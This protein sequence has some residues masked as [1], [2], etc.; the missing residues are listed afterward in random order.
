VSHFAGYLLRPGGQRDRG[1]EQAVLERMARSP[2]LTLSVQGTDRF[3]LVC[4]TVPARRADDLVLHAEGG[5]SVLAGEPLNGS[6]TEPAAPAAEALFRRDALDGSVRSLV[7]SPGTFAVAAW[8]PR[9]E[10]LLLATDHVA[11]R[12]LYFISD[13]QHIAFATSLRLL[14]ALLP[15]GDE[16]DEQGVAE[17]VFFGQCLGSRTPFK[18]VQVLRPGQA[19]RVDAR[20]QP[21]AHD[22]LDRLNRP[23]EPVP[24]GDIVQMLHHAFAKAVSRR[25]RPGPQEAFLSGGMDSR[26]VVAALTD[27]GRPVRSFCTAYAGSLDDIVSRE[28]A[29]RLGTRH[30]IKHRTPAERVRVA[31][32]PFAQYARE[33]FPPESGPAVGRRLWSGDGG[34]V[35]LGHVYM[36]RDSVA[37]AAG[38]L[39]HAALMQLFPALGRRP[40]RQLSR[41]T[42]ARWAELAEAGAA[43]EFQRLS[44]APP[45]RRL[46]HFYMQNDQARHLYHH[47][48]G[49]DLNGIELLT[50]FFDGDFVALVSRLPIEPF[51][52]HGIY[53]RW[54][55]GFR[56]GAGEVYW[57][58][59]RGHEPCPHP[60]PV[61]TAD[62]WDQAW[63]AGAEVRRA[64]RDIARQVLGRGPSAA[65]RFVS[66][67][68][69]RAFSWFNAAGS[70]RFDHEIAFA[71]N[72]SSLFS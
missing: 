34:S 52:A 23:I 61:V 70:T 44:G 7:A 31:L 30:V 50:P 19:L 6:D 1:R 48:D 5:V 27:A 65:D 59:Y 28:V 12:S 56:C 25:L 10:T 57:Q 13:D 46:F 15:S 58:T 32:D 37:V 47:F 11:S 42:T 41:Q 45:E 21:S 26:A 14:R 38:R 24:P 60:A 69:L 8:N 54:I 67:P 49:I 39:D 33:H 17:T 9:T 16:V 62:Q 71:R 55:R 2:A 53:N 68:M 66:R 51:L 35:T 29:Q 64:Y 22:Y 40:T 20:W 72:I 4:Q 43:A 36:N 63:Y 3:W 18:N